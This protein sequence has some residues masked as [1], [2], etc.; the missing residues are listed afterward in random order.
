M[1]RQQIINTIRQ[2]IFYPLYYIIANIKSI[3]FEDMF[4][5][6]LFPRNISGL[7]I[8]QLRKLKQFDRAHHRSKQAKQLKQLINQYTIYITKYRYK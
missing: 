3:L 6:V 7:R 4:L 8:F 5:I 2:F 1:E